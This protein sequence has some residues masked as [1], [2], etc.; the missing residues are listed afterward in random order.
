[1]RKYLVHF[2]PAFFAVILMA[3][4][5]KHQASEDPMKISSSAFAPGA[6]FP[7]IYSCKGENQSPPLAWDKVPPNTKSLALIMDDPDAPRGTFVHWLAWNIDPKLM[8]LTAHLLPT[9]PIAILSQGLNSAGKKGYIGPCPPAG[10]HRYYFKLYALDSVL[11]LPKDSRKEE[12]VQEMAGHI[13]G[14]AELMATFSAEG[15]K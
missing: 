2:I 4:S 6:A 11:S 1:M 8:K 13:I 9:A 15:M 7:Q 14:T 3:P 10:I 12:L 5:C